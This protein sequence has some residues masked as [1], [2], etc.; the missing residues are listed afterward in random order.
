[1]CIKWRQGAYS[2][3]CCWKSSGTMHFVGGLLGT[4]EFEGSYLFLSSYFITEKEIN[5]HY[6][7]VNNGFPTLS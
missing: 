5:H 4:Y 1:M 2:N 6:K 3:I 7:H